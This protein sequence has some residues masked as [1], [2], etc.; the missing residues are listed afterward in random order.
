MARFALIIFIV[1]W[2]VGCNPTGPENGWTPT[3]QQLNGQKNVR[4]LVSATIHPDGTV[5]TWG[6]G[7][8]GTLG[9]GSLESSETPVQAIG[10]NNAIAIDLFAGVAVAADNKGNIYFWGDYA[11]YS[12]PP[13]F[14]TI[15]VVPTIVSYLSGVKSLVI[16]IRQLFYFLR[17]D[18]SVW[19]VQFDHNS[20]TKTLKPIK[21]EG[22]SDAIQVTE[23]YALRSNGTIFD[24]IA[25]IPNEL[26]PPP[27]RGGPVPNLGNIIQVESVWFRRTVILKNDGTVWA[28]GWNDFGQL[29]NGTFQDSEEPVRVGNLTNIVA[30]SA[31]YDYNLAL[32]RDG[33][34]WFWGLEYPLEKRGTSTPVQIQK[35]KKVSTIYADY[36]S[37][38]LCEDGSYWS[39]NAANKIP[40][41]ILF[42]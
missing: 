2:I 1:I 26:S 19:Y 5:W 15:V 36:N 34:V 39:F 17:N 3:L 40:E 16:G 7:V 32:T 25:T 11:V 12:E 20:P 38:V 8:F 18:G 22:L 27:D 33:I 42:K 21:I 9:T 41:Q 23:C 4:D 10:I 14:D 13:G 37:L 28:W 35:L 6:L 24:L 31:H 30:I 29:G